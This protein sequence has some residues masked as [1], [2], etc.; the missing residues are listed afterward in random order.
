MRK[1]PYCHLQLGLPEEQDPCTQ[2]GRQCCLMERKSPA[3]DDALM[4]PDGSSSECNHLLSSRKGTHS[5]NQASLA[6]LRQH[7]CGCSH[8][9]EGQGPACIVR[10]VQ[11]ELHESTTAPT[12]MGA[13]D[14]QGQALDA[15]VQPDPMR[16]VAVRTPA[17][18]LAGLGTVPMPS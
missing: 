5:N 14:N 15:V 16:C 13:E 9:K 2:P 6:H 7:S 1:L 11:F 17:R 3:P 12:A 18:W 8:C 4:L 10:R